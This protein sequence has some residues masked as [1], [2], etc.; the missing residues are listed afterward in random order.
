MPFVVPGS[1][2]G[3]SLSTIVGSASGLSSNGRSS[4]WSAAYTQLSHHVALGIGTGGFASLNLGLPYPHNIVL[5]IALE[6]GVVGLLAFAVMAV[7]M[8]VRMSRLW[9]WT[10]GE[11]RLAISLLIAPDGVGV[12]QRLLLGGVAGQ[13]RPVEMGRD[14]DRDVRRL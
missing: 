14:R 4:L 8:S 11:D 2:I 13:L 9:R 7:S 3:R 6:L 10:R 1:A 5:E 12:R